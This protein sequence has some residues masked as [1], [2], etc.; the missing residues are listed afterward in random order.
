MHVLK[1]KIEAEVHEVRSD[2]EFAG[3]FLCSAVVQ[4]SVMEKLKSWGDKLQLSPNFD[5]WINYTTGSS[6]AA[7]CSNPIFRPAFS[8]DPTS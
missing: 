3:R 5:G 2:H 8:M 1:S 4:D 7:Y 6:V